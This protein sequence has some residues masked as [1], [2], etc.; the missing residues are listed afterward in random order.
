LLGLAQAAA[1]DKPGMLDEDKVFEHAFAVSAGDA[2]E[3]GRGAH[4]GVVQALA[5][6]LFAAPLGL[7]AVVQ[8]QHGVVLGPEVE[9]FDVSAFGLAIRRALGFALSGGS[10]FDGVV[11]EGRVVVG[12][13]WPCRGVIA[14]VDQCVGG[15]QLCQPRQF[16][17]LALPPMAST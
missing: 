11:R 7:H 2:A 12:Q 14:V 16:P 5:Q 1:L 9:V 15:Q 13:T 3:S 8:V 4:A 17:N 6:A 10:G